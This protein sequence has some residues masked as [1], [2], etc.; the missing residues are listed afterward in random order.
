MVHLP[1]NAKPWDRVTSVSHSQIFSLFMAAP[2]P[3]LLCDVE[4]G[5]N[6]CP[7]WAEVC[8]G[9]VS[10]NSTAFREDLSPPCLWGK[11]MCV[12]PMSRVWDPH[13][14]SVSPKSSNQPRRLVSST[15]DPRTGVSRMWFEL[16]APQGGCPHSLVI[17]VFL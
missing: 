2:D 12:L 16:L 6:F 13:S 8:C 4:W 1:I 15:L 10:R 3:V 11:S 5:Q 17:S 7:S 14:P 9:E